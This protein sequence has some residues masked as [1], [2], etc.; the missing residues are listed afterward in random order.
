MYKNTG[1]RSA[2]IVAASLEVHCPF[3][4]EPQPAPDNGAHTWM[5]SQVSA[6]Q[7]KCVCVACE[8]AFT[9]HAQSRV[10]VEV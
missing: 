3:C 4:G 10:S 8:E 6:A 2:V 1:K 7:G 9:I 5:P